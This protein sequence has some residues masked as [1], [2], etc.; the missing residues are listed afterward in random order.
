MHLKPLTLTASELRGKKKTNAGI[1]EP[2][3]NSMP[4][5]FSEKHSKHG[6]GSSFCV[7]LRAGRDIAAL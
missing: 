7:L 2:L 3:E 6:S 5:T 4:L 1:N